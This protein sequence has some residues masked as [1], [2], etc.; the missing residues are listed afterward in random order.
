V[1]AVAWGV[2][3]AAGRRAGPELGLPL[4]ILAA[5]ALQA[6]VDWSWAVPALTVPALA[7]A[8]VVLA[9]AEPA[10]AWAPGGPDPLVAGT[11]AGFTAMAV[12]S[13]LL[14]WWST[15][16]ADAGR[17]ALAD[18][19]PR[20]ALERADQAR[21]LNPLSLAP[22]LLRAAALDDLDERA[23]ALGAYEAATRL[24]PDNPAAWRALAV[25]LGRDE[26]AAAAWRQVRRL[27]P[28]DLEA[29]LRAGA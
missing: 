4:A 9:A 22:L 15:R 17:D 20:V 18:G 8:G 13:A 23:R 24:Q 1:A 28:Q 5:F 26:R 25:F 16:E 14:P 3:R 19:R 10:R 27:D 11:I 29:A 2:V 21:E 7:A 12:A 6:A